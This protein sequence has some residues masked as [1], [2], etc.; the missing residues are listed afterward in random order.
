M[1][2]VKR[3]IAVC[4]LLLLAG[5]SQHGDVPPM[6]P[7][8]EAPAPS[9]FTVTTADS[10][11]YDLSWT[12][13]EPS[14]VAFY[15]LYNLDLFTGFP[16]FIDTTAATAAQIDVVIP[17]PGLVFGVSSVST[18]NVESRITFGSAP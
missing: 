9:S 5:C 7:I 4:M 15:Q 8:V 1:P 14:T 10:I 3:S 12:N 18:S 11:I 2:A 16:A 6:L 17:V 13:T